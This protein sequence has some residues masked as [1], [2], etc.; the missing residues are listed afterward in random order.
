MSQIVKYTC[1]ELGDAEI[2]C[3]VVSGEP[4]IKGVEVA[5]LLGYE[6]PRTAVRKHVPLKYKNTLGFLVRTLGVSAADMQS[7]RDLQT[8]WI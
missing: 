5:T 4:W 2:S 7:A 1:E 6:R 8:S 3:L